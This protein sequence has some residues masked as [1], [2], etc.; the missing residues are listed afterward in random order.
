M[1]TDSATSEPYDPNRIVPK[2]PLA[3]WNQPA[4]R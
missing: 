3:D 2:G 1:E 4:V